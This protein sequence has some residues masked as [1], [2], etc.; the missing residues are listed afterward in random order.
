MLVGKSL[1]KE[2]N[3]KGFHIGHKEAKIWVVQYCLYKG[4]VKRCS[5]L[6]IAQL[7]KL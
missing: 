1:N 4:R 6:T 7:Q 3:G 5:E 2:I